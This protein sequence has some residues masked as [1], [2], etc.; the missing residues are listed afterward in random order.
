MSNDSS[1]KVVT[2]S[3]MKGRSASNVVIIVCTCVIVIT[4]VIALGIFLKTN[5]S[6]AMEG[7]EKQ[8]LREVLVTQD[9]AEEVLEEIEERPQ[10]RPEYYRVSM[11]TEWIFEDGI[12]SSKDAFVK[13]PDTNTNAVYF[14]VVCT[15]TGETIYSSPV[16]PVGS[17]LTDITLDKDLDAG[18]YDCVLTY[19]LVDDAQNTLGTLNVSVTVIVQN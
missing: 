8:A 3:S 2:D 11:T 19:H 4:I 9:N 12:S 1:K 14:D 5:S 6:E 7:S 18:T 13:N 16:I 17:S 10:V 15:E